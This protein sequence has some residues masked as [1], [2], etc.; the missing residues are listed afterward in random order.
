MGAQ[1]S[2]ITTSPASAAPVPSGSSSITAPSAT[3]ACPMR[4]ICASAKRMVKKPLSARP[5]VMP[6]KKRLA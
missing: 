3:S 1:P 2:P 4:I 6:M 5:T